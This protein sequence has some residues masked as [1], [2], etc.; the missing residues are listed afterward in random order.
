MLYNGGEDESVT[1]TQASTRR[2]SEMVTDRTPMTAE[3]ART[4]RSASMSNALLLLAKASERG[5]NC[6]PYEDWFTYHRW[7]AQEYSVRKGEHG[8]KLPVIVQTTDEE[9]GATRRLLHRSVVFCRC[10]VDKR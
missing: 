5:C 3:E 1:D 7:Q 10:Q 8:V 4:F 9:T 2:V 6:Q